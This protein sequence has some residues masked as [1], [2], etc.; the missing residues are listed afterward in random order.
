MEA[1]PLHPYTSPIPPFDSVVIFAAGF[2]ISGGGGVDL[3]ADVVEDSVFVASADVIVA[4]A[5]GSAHLAVIAFPEAAVT[6]T[7][8]SVDVAAASWSV[9]HLPV[10]DGMQTLVTSS[11]SSSNLPSLRTTY[12]ISPS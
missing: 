3:A 8:A 11:Q 6:A 9:E 1:F 5:G 2:L 10:E 7:T 4:S 12:Q